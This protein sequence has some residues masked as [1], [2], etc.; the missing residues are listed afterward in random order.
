MLDLT[1]VAKRNVALGVALALAFL[2]AW[3][4]ISSYGTMREER[5]ANREREK[6]QAAAAAAFAQDVKDVLASG[7]TLTDALAHL[8]N[9]EPK[10]VEKYKYVKVANP[11][12]AGCRV[13]DV[14]LHHISSAIQKANAAAGIEGA[15]QAVSGTNN[16]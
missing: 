15:V 5:G 7:E 12:P 1:T 13:D 16:K 3:A 14:R 10:I 4:A 6:A 11:L 8:S 9:L 2:C